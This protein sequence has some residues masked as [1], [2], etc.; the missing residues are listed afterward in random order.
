MSTLFGTLNAHLTAD[1]TKQ[2]SAL[3]TNSA[4]INRFDDEIK[5]LNLTPQVIVVDSTTVRLVA[6]SQRGRDHAPLFA[7]LTEKGFKV[8][9]AEK[10]TE[11]FFDGYAMWT[12]DITSR[13]MSFCLRFYTEE[14]VSV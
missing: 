1:Y 12:A 11:Q 13:S 10:T 2:T 14:D 6:V 8:G 7:A 5:P 4:L 3:R 9:K